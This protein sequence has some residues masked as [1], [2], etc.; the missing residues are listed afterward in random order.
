MMDYLEEKG[1]GKRTVTYHLRDWLISRQRYWGPPIPMIYCEACAKEG[2]SWFITQKTVIPAKA[3][4]PLDQGIPHQVRDDNN[5]DWNA[6]G[7]YPVPE[8][9]LPVLLPRIEDYKPSSDG[10]APLSKHKEFFDTVCPYCGKPAVR[11]TDVS[12][13]FLDSSWYFLRYPSL[14]LEDRV[15]KV[16]VEN[17]CLA[18]RQGKSKIEKNSDPSSINYLLPLS[19]TFNHLVSDKQLPW[20]PQITR[21]WLPVHMYT[22]GAEHSVLHLLY[23]RFVWKCLYDW[24]YFDFSAKGRP[25]SGWDEPFTNFFAHGLIIKNGMK[26]SKSKGNVVNLDEYIPKYGADAIRLYLMFMGPLSMGGDFSDTG[27]EGMSRW[28][29]RVWRIILRSIHSHGVLSRIFPRPTSSS[30]VSISRH[31][32]SIDHMNTLPPVKQDQSGNLRDC[33]RS[34]GIP[35]CAT[36]QDSTI[37][38]SDIVKRLLEKTIAKITDDMEKRRYNTA[39]ASLMELTNAI[40]DEGGALGQEELKKYILLLAPFAPHM[41]E[42]A[43]NRLNCR[44]TYTDPQDSIHRQPW[45]S[46]DPRL[47]EDEKATIVVQINGKTRGTIAIFQNDAKNQDVVETRVRGEEKFAKHFTGPVKKTIFVPGK[48]INFV[49]S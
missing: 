31:Y 4:I 38:T 28:V 43:W 24:G 39:I 30:R 3:G 13:T 26:M 40:V 29:S 41:S 36:P 12:D 27:M 34:T 10:I 19:S 37:Q 33:G 1:W 20:D 46:Y 6:V 23:S 11:E 2:K 5:N 16:G 25:A 45:P 15:L 9:Q 17:T 7:W 42:E 35:L 22:G 44:Q 32:Q 18:G 21:R 47:I 49:L 48:L 14:G 8:D